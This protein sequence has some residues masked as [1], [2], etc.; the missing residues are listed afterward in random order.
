MPALVVPFSAGEVDYEC[1]RGLLEYQKSQGTTHAIVNGTTG[2]SP[3]L[4]DAE[5]DKLVAMA[6][7]QLSVIA[8]TG[9]NNTEK[10]LKR[11]GEAVALGASAL[12]LVDPYYNGPSSLELRNEYYSPVAEKYSC[13]VIPYVIPGRTGCELSAYDLALLSKEHGN[14]Y[15]VKEAT[16]NLERMRLTRTLCPDML[17]YSGDDDL[18]FRMISDQAIRSCGVI[19]VAA[20]VFPAAVRK[21][22]DLAIAK[23]T[24]EASALNA[25]MAPLFSAIT[26][27]STVKS[28]YGYPGEV[29]Q[30]FRNPIAYKA[31]MAGLGMMEFGCRRPLGKMDKAGVEFVRAAARRVW[32]DNPEILSPLESAFDVDVSARIEDDANW[33]MYYG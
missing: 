13:P 2:E 4:T 5:Q 27:K 3:T 6:S 10:T 24:E 7:S 25:A 31:L 28:P 1:Y 33:G 14:I 29:V 23:K 16:G 19:S 22:V 12:L 32:Q 21:M 15:A 9:S 18:T 26:V 30:K 11:S 20:N 17:I 8:G